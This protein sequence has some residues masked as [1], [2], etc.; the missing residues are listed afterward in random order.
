MEDD[1]LSKIPVRYDMP[2]PGDPSSFASGI[3]EP[4][5]IKNLLTL[6]DNSACNVSFK[7][8]GSSTPCL[9]ERPVNPQA[10]NQANPGDLYAW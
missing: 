6:S 2:F 10:G 4:N 3:C 1:L 7:G 5:C 9:K 8:L